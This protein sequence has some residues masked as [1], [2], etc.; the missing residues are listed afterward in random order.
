MFLGN[1]SLISKLETED[2][3]VSEEEVKEFS[4]GEATQK[5]EEPEEED[6]EDLVSASLMLQTSPGWKTRQTNNVTFFDGNNLNSCKLDG[7]AF[8]SAFSL[9]L[10]WFY[11]LLSSS[12]S[13]DKKKPF[14]NSIFDGK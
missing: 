3:G 10:V 2:G 5:Q 13:V 7:F 6:S 4:A 9:T 12:G 11:E 14:H 1:L 8:Q